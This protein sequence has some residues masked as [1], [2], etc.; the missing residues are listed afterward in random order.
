MRRLAAVIAFAAGACAAAPD[1]VPVNAALPPEITSASYAPVALGVDGEALALSFSGGGA[2]A[3]AFAHG[4]MLELRDTQAADGGRLA[5]D[6]ALITAVSGGSITAAWIGLHGMDGLDGFRGAALD[7]DWTSEL[8]V[9]ALAPSNWVRFLGQ[10][11]VN[12]PDELA[13]WLDREVYNGARMNAL[14][15]K[16][17][18][19]INATEL[20]TA[21]PFAFTSVYFDA[22]CSDLGGVRI[23]DAVAASMA[24]PVVFRPVL[25]ETYAGECPHPTGSL[26]EL[27]TNDRRAP[28]VVRDTASAFQRFRDA[29]VMRY[30]HL[31]DGGVVD[32]FGLASLIVM[33][34]ASGAPYAPLTPRDAVK[35]KRL[36]VL[37]VNSELDVKA[38]WPLSPKGPTGAQVLGTSLD[39]A[40]NA[41]KRMSLEAF[42]GMLDQ[43]KRD[44][45]AWRC[46]LTATEA[47]SHGAAPGWRCAD[48]DMRLD[49]ISFADLPA[50]V[51]AQLG[52]IPTAVSLPRASIDALIAGGRE[53]TRINPLVRDLA[54]PH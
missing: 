53:A 13:G 37:V 27:A 40:I 52:E 39:V 49:V 43:W 18:I 54:A 36:T 6:V 26:M 20:F 47:L 32:N 3:A 4:V 23:A 12:G 48:I 19:V 9:S 33:R 24:V 5:D 1:P 28:V 21:S 45:V 51:H 2:R 11:G 15:A 30:L 44:L 34:R 38:D 31:V 41:N 35:L 29:D 8:R 25:V 7:K 42:N 50:D 17:R 14:Q 22:I 10:G 46:R 16:P